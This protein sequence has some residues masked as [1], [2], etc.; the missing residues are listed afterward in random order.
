MKTKFASLVLFACSTTLA[1][2]AV[3]AYPDRPIRVIVPY[4]AG[5]STDTTARLIGG[6]LTERLGQQVVVDNRAGGG[7][8]IGTQ[9]AVR[10]APDG[11]TLLMAT[12]PFV[13]NLSLRSKV[14]YALGDFIPIGNV[15]GSSNLLVVHP[16]VPAKSTRELIALLKANPGKYT[17]GSS[18][19]AGAGHLAMALLES[20]AG[21]QA[22]H[23]PYKGGPPAV[24]DLV[25]GRVNMM[26]GNLTTSQGHIKA[27]RLRALAIG[28]KKRSPLV[29]DL[30]T[31]SES[32]VP[33][34][35][36]TNWNGVVAPKGTPRE[37][38]ERLNREIVSIL[39]EPQV[40]A[41]MTK[42]YLDPIG[43]SPAEFAQYLESEA[44][45]WAKL[46]KSAGIRAD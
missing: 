29:P 43:D 40:L 35:E 33:G 44:A 13:A 4:A 26:M 45:K 11:H 39:K 38:I 1:L 32:G 8:L 37:I 18:G 10:A 17:Y 6:R 24:A 28:T 36:M 9:I 23:V 2:D 34:Y 21:F 42:V 27:G 15:S 7:T 22:V 3:P 16:A 19:V 31:L 30:P 14:P 20:M 12:P 41:F 5:G 46:V 25:A